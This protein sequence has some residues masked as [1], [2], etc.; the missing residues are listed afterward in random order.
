[1][2]GTGLG[3]S[4]VKSIVEQH[5]GEVRLDSKLNQGTTVHIILPL[6]EPRP[7]GQDNLDQTSSRD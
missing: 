2:P 4:I 6:R 1:V 3:L 7:P 5:R